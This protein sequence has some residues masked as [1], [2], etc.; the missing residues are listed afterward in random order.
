LFLS[1]EEVDKERA[2]FQVWLDQISLRTE[3]GTL[4]YFKPFEDKEDNIM[5]CVFFGY[6]LNLAVNYYQNKY[7]VKLAK[8]D[9]NLGDA[10]IL[11]Y[12][13]KQPALVIYQNFAISFGKASFT[14]CSELDPKIINAFIPK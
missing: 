9:G 6:Y 12:Q 13:K 7:L 10:T 11:A 5:A 3:S 1:P 2:K 14:I 4:P 8:I